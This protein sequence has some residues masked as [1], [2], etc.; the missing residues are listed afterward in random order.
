[1]NAQF[2]KHPPLLGIAILGFSIAENVF[3]CPVGQLLSTEEQLELI[4]C[5][6]VE[7]LH[8]KYMVKPT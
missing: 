5:E 8:G 6:R 1:M 2:W 3:P 4:R 7:A